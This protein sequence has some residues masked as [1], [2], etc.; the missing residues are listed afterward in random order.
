M[1]S[2]SSTLQKQPTTWQYANIPRPPP[3]S[4][5]TRADS[6]LLAVGSQPLRFLPFRR[7]VL[8][9]LTKGRGQFFVINRLAQTFSSRGRTVEKSSSSD[10]RDLLEKRPVV[11]T[12][13]TWEPGA[14]PQ[15]VGR[16]RR[17]SARW[18]ASAASFS[19]SASR[20]FA[21]APL[22]TVIDRQLRRLAKEIGPQPTRRPPIPTEC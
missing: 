10:V 13:R 4:P 17:R 1:S 16:A 9:S 3:M 15:A 11:W 14:T 12:G 7:I 18:Y 2:L 20:R 22:S 8:V 19:A 21:A 5:A 6:S